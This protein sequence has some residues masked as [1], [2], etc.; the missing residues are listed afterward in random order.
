VG[1]PNSCLSLHAVLRMHLTSELPASLSLLSNVFLQKSLCS[2]WSGLRVCAPLA[3]LVAGL[4][5]DAPTQPPQRGQDEK[6]VRGE[7][8]SLVVDG[9]TKGLCRLVPARTGLGVESD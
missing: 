3:S 8:A 2:P 9:I 1:G 7:G 6:S 4:R 5:L